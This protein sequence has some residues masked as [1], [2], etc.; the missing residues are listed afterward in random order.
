M[1]FPTIPE[2]SL[3]QDAHP[4]SG[5]PPSA[6]M[7]TFGRAAHARGW[8]SRRN[9]GTKPRALSL[10]QRMPS[11]C[12]S[13]DPDSTPLPMPGRRRVQ[14]QLHGHVVGHGER[15]VI[16]GEDLQVGVQGAAAAGGDSW[17]PAGG[18][19]SSLEPF[20]GCW[21]RS[22]WRHRSRR[23]DRAFGTRWRRPGSR[24][25]ARRRR[26]GSGRRGGRPA[27]RC[28]GPAGGR[29]SPCSVGAGLE[30]DLGEVAGQDGV[31]GVADG[32]PR[33]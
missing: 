31:A 1:M 22:G 33:V 2:P 14:L 18:A 10:S 20:R 9:V 30:L 26:G 32:S 7:P 11:P 16:G 6:A 8:A 12:A 15:R 13:A 4:R 19:L 24:R 17:E 21:W 29:R 28:G 3:G 25:C 5:R 27:L 23:R